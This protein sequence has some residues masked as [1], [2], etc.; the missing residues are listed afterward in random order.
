MRIAA[1]LSPVI[2]SMVT[3]CSWHDAHRYA[4]SYPNIEQ[5]S[6]IAVESRYEVVD[7]ASFDSLLPQ[8]DAARAKSPRPWIGGGCVVHEP[9]YRLSDPHNQIV[10]R[11]TQVRELWIPIN[12]K[13]ER[14]Y[15]F[16]VR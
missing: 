8:N 6:P 11:L 2:L 15:E 12:G 7:V 16:E 3:G 13:T 1:A 9:E 10:I 14:Y 4:I 5:P